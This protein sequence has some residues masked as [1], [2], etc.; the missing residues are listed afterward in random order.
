[1]HKL[2]DTSVLN[3][4]GKPHK[5]M[6]VGENGCRW[7]AIDGKMRNSGIKIMLQS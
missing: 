6:K 1:M 2:R 3:E 7:E 5:K 4:N